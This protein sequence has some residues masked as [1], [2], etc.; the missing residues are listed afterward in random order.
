VALVLS[1]GEAMDERHV[2]F[3]E[4]RDHLQ[5][6]RSARAEQIRKLAVK[7]GQGVSEI[8][9]RLGISKTTVS[10]TLR[11]LGIETARRELFPLGLPD[12]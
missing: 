8:A 4:Q 11:A 6:L 12:G 1:E 5:R 2:A 10:K 3:A 7:E 9:R